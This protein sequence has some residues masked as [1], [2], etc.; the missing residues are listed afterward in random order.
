LSFVIPPF[1]PDAYLTDH[2]SLKIGNLEVRVLHTPGHAPGHVSFY[3]PAENLLIGGDLIIGG[4]IGRIDLADSNPDD[5]E[6]S[7][8]R[9]MELPDSTRLLGGHGPASTIG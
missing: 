8:K 4:S 5:M 7:I 2:Q 1:K 3:F 9:V 6:S